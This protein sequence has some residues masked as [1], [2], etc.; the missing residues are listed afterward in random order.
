MTRIRVAPA[1][2]RQL[3]VLFA[4]LASVWLTGLLLAWS[5]S[6]AA[7][8]PGPVAGGATPPGGPTIQAAPQRWK[9]APPNA[10]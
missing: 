6:V 9:L 8:G 4:L 1:S 3:I 10:A 2:V 7:G 5:I